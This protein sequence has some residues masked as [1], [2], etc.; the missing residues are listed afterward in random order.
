MKNFDKNI[1]SNQAFL[2][3]IIPVLLVLVS[4]GVW[5]LMFVHGKP[6]SDSGKWVQLIWSIVAVLAF[7][8]GFVIDPYDQ[9]CSDANFKAFGC[10]NP[11][12]ISGWK[13]SLIHWLIL[14]LIYLYITR[15]FSLKKSLVV[16]FLLTFV[17]LLVV[18]VLFLGV[19][20]YELC[21]NGA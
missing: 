20:K 17:S 7:I 9:L 21:I 13:T 5:S 14:F 8:V 19:M 16:C 12:G 3:F 1:F 6:I 15:S 10:S 4:F 18:Y 11:F 2:K